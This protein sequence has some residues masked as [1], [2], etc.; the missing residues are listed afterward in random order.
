MVDFFLFLKYKHIEIIKINKD[1]ICEILKLPSIK[2][3]V[4]NP[5]INILANEYVIKYISD[6]SPLNFLFL[7]FIINKTNIIALHIDSYKKVG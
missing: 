1:R 4:L 6:I 7:D 2:L 3:S 5:S